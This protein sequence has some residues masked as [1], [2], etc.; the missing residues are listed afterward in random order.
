VRNHLIAS[1]S[2][3]PD[4]ADA[5]RPG[6][7]T[8]DARRESLAS[9]AIAGDLLPTL[10]LRPTTGGIARPVPAGAAVRNPGALPL[11][12]ARVD[13]ANALAPAREPAAVHADHR[14]VNQWELLTGAAHM[15]LGTKRWRSASTM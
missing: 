12:D 7:P 9:R 6:R 15:W 4:R 8:P 3:G 14:A 1:L 2:N 5:R 13:P 10:A 11:A